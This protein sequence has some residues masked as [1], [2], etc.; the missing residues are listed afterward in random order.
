VNLINII[1]NEVVNERD[2][3]VNFNGIDVHLTIQVD[4]II[5]DFEPKITLQDLIFSNKNNSI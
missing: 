5:E 2:N 4:S 3:I 1:H